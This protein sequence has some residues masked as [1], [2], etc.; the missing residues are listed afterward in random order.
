[1]LGAFAAPPSHR[2]MTRTNGRDA[3]HM[4]IIVAYPLSRYLV[5]HSR[6]EKDDRTTYR[7]AL[8]EVDADVLRVRVMAVPW[9]HETRLI[10]KSSARLS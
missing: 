3:S 1:M 4:K 2:S 6:D 7:A 10:S 5:A 8:G 9:R